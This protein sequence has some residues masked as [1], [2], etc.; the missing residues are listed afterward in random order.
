VPSERYR[1]FV[2]I[3]ADLAEEVDLPLELRKEILFTEAHLER[4]THWEA[5]GLAWNAS[6][7]EA[8]AAYRDK[9]MVFHPDRYSNKRLGSYRKRLERIFRRLTHAK[10]VLSDQARRAAYAEETAPPEEVTRTD[11]LRLQGE[12]RSAERR[13]R[14]ARTNPLVKRAARIAELVERG[15][16]AMASRKFA[17]AAN[18]FLT[19]VG[20]DPSNAVARELG[21]EAKRLAAQENARAAYER[22]LAAEAAGNPAAA[23]AC[24][25]EAVEGDPGNAR[26]AALA[27]R[28][29]LRAGDAEQAL[30]L[31]EG[32]AR[33]GPRDALA[34]EVLGEVLA[35]AGD[36]RGAR[37][38]LERALAIEPGLETARAQL[39]KLR[40][41]FLG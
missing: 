18:D 36:S 22:G 37:K 20:L 39:K 1:D 9:V 5:L 29:A 19:V 4:W 38:A 41:S 32:A 12:R 6:A 8:R 21:Q 3:P 27:A 15:K 28:L 14:L 23:L 7:D 25:Q 26:Y 30:R 40:W 33:S 13:A 11:E 16:K 34:H 2:F 35:A 31:A 24:F 10:D 17:S